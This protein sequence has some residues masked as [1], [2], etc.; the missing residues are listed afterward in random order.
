MPEANV[1][2]IGK[3]PRGRIDPDSQEAVV[4]LDIVQ[5]RLEE[6]QRLY[7][8][9]CQAADDFSQAIKSSAEESGLLAKVLR[10]F[11]VALADDKV[12]EKKREC[13][14]LSFLFEE[15]EISE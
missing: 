4:K 9:S 3:P 13:E 8:A 1:T 6:L 11:V 12:E 15:V 5:E 10:R 7:I 14:Q 2:A